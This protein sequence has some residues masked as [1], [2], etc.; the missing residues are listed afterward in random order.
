[1][2]VSDILTGVQWIWWRRSLAIADRHIEISIGTENWLTAHVVMASPLQDLHFTFELDLWNGGI[3][4]A[5]ARKL[6]TGFRFRRV[7]VRDVAPR[8]FWKLWME[9]DSECREMPALNLFQIDCQLNVRISR[10]I[11]RIDLS[12]LLR[13]NPPIGAGHTCHVRR[14]LQLNRSENR[15]RRKR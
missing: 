10:T 11:E 12:V 2:Q 14:L 8:L 15:L 1:M 13:D 9:S 3:D 4:N 6:C 7:F 5:K